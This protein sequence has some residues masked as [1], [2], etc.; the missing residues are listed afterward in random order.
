MKNRPSCWIVTEGFAGM[1]NQCLGLAEALGLTGQMKRIHRPRSA[2]TYLPPRFWPNP[3]VS[4]S[5]ELVPPWP[6]IVISSGRG[7]VAAAL[8]ICRRG[9]GSTFSVH[10]QTPYVHPHRFDL[11]IIPEH[12]GLRGENVVVTKTAL[13]RVTKRSLDEAERLFKARMSRLPRPL[14]AV[15]VGGPTKKLECSSETMRRLASQLKVAAGRCGGALAVTTSRRTGKQNEIALRQG[16]VATPQFFWNG[17]GENPYLGI[18]ALA[19]AIVVTS[20]SVSMVSEACATGKPVHIFSLGKE[21]KKLRRFHKSLMDSGVTRPFS[22][23]IEHWSY[24][25]P[26][27]TERVAAIVREYLSQALFLHQP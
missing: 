26:N 10:I 1:E 2:L 8:A 11:V 14:I 27:D 24:D 21:P 12:D 4:H 6:E 19:D 16:L 9:R 23:V 13:H 22:G 17:K 3:I 5:R 7:S 15:L 25:P 18:L 20:D